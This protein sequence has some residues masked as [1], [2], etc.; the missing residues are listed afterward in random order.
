MLLEILVFN[1]EIYSL[2]ELVSY[3]D[4][5]FIWYGLNEDVGNW[6]CLN[7]FSNVFSRLFGLFL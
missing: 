7:C 3:C 6:V 1:L 4:R 5:L 2:D